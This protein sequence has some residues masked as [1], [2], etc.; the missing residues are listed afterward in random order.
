M[1]LFDKLFPRAAAAQQAQGYFKTLTAYQPSFTTWNGAIYESE[2][3]RAAIDARARHNSKLAISFTGT[4]Q[5]SL[6]AKL[7]IAPNEWQTWSQFF[8]RL[9]TILDNQNTAFIVPVYNQYG[10]VTGIYPVL[11]SKCDIVESH[12][13]PYLRYTFRTGDKASIELGLCGIMTRFQY[14]DDFFGEGNSALMPT[15]ELIHAQNQ[16]IQEGIKNAATYRFMAKVNNFTKPEDLTKERK[17]FSREN[18]AGEDGGGLLLFPNT[19]TDIQ[20][21]T[22]KPFT[23]DAAQMAAIKQ[24]VFNYFGVNDAILQNS[25][26]DEQLDSFFNGAIE[27]F[28]IQLSDVLSKM[29]FSQ[30]EV[31]V[32]NK[33]FVTANRLQYMS[34]SHKISMAQQL[35]D[36]G[37]ITIDEIRALFNYPPLEDGA[38]KKAPI[39]GEYYFANEEEKNDGDNG[40]DPVG[41]SVQEP[42]A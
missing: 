31:A 41:D 37:M 24:N 34:V 19:Y 13:V 26:S 22:S 21:I 25:A 8:Y 39:R 33:V 30:R 15:M 40:Q 6:Q 14:T 32:G 38:G 4:A 36:R 20:Q 42:D 23:V 1:G 11:P 7:K 10:D 27:P 9:S 5:R 29:F 35:G 16:G 28:A 12:N 18:F 2:L 3:V 17:R